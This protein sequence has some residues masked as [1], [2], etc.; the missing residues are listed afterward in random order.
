MNEQK[1]VEFLKNAMSRRGFL[2]AAGA[3]AVG[4]ALAACGTG[5]STP[6][7]GGASTGAAAF[8]ADVSDT[9]K[10]VRWANWPL[11]LD[12]DEDAKTYPTLDAFAA[13]S[14]IAPTYKEE[15]D[16]NA[17]FWGK[18]NGQLKTGQDIG[19]DVVTPTDWMASRFIQ[20]GYAQP[21]DAAKIPNKVN[22]L[23][24][25]ANVSFDKGRNYSLTWQSGFGGLVW[26]K[27]KLPNGLQS[28]D[29][30]WSDELKGKVTVLS[31]MRDTMGIILK[32]LGI[33]I[34]NGI[35]EDQWQQGLEFLGGKLDDGSIYKVQGNEYAKDLVSGQAWAGIVWSGD[36]FILNAENDD[37][38]GFALPESGGMLWSDN[39]LIP[40]TS[41]HQSNAMAMM[42]HYYDPAVAAQVAAYV[43]YICPVKGAQAEMEK[44]DPALAASEFIFPTAETLTK[45]SVFPALDS[46]AEQSF[47]DSWATTTG[48]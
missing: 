35:T 32:S 15:I 4:G 44:I 31:E 38:W 20:Y 45:A 36:I 3:V 9:E 34:T 5:G 19:F 47:S 8:P 14:G 7:A 22:I 28:V 1:S 46:A 13:A 40:S 30:L 11:Y 33:D 26:N 41:S 6:A 18:V 23:D 17:T 29:Q 27:E 37:K 42:N 25:L 48:V 21:L 16:D 2:G 24:N 10:V 12:Y 39:M 43:N